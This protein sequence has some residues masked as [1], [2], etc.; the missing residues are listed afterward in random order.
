MAQA[1]VTQFANTLITIPSSD[2]EAPL[3]KTIRR[4]PPISI[5][6]TGLAD[7]DKLLKNKPTTQ[8]ANTLIT[9][10]SSD[11]ETSSI[12]L[13]DEDKLLENKSIQAK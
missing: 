2:D 11:D 12:W 6:S 5:P 4:T 13:S 9:I 3:K 7:G 1:Y 10:S 8:F